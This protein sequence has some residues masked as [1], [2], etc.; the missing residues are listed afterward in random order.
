MW[1]AKRGARGEVEWRVWSVEC[2]VWSVGMLSAEY[3][4]ER[5]VEGSA[6]CGGCRM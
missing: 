3:S 5:R 4:V 2:G 1:S 6:S